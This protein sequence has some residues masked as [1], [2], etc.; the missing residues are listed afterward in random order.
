MRLIDLYFYKPLWWQKIIIFLLLPLSCFYCVIALLK[1]KFSFKVDFGIP[2]I[3]VG[4]LVVGG[5][6]KTPFII[7]I[8]QF[9]AHKKV[10]II[11]R[12]YKRKSKGLVVVSKEGELLCSQEEAGDEAYLIAC[13]LRNA[14][15]IVCK[16]RKD[17]IRKAIEMGCEIVFLDDGFRFNF[18]KLNIVLKP[19]LEPYYPFCL[20]SGMYREWRGAYGEADLVVNEGVDYTRE[21]GIENPSERMLLV[22]AIANPMRLDEFLPSV[23]GKVYYPDHSR[24]DFEVLKREFLKYQ[25]TSLL[26]TSKDAVK[27]EGL[28]L[29]LSLLQLRL[30]I[31]SKVIEKI[32][33]Y[34]KE[35]EC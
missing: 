14:S 33:T 4:N 13:S 17:A 32:N 24:F 22:T 25:A 12:G 28:D 27:L 35:R 9:Y 23:V 16:K 3:S 20:P 7:E 2:I 5:S 15:V 21:V 29:P 6:G 34:L 19:K 31:D 11:S 8:A 30:Q 1:R 10:A 26:I 18:Q